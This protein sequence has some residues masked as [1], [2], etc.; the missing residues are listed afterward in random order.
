M[1]TEE[2]KAFLSACD[3]PS[4]EDCHTRQKRCLV[5]RPDRYG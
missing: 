4:G 3:W 5:S 1:P 2:E